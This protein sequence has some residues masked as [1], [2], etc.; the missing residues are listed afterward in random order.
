[1][2]RSILLEIYLNIF[3]RNIKL[4]LIKMDFIEFL[5]MNN[6]NLEIMKM[7]LNKELKVM[8]NGT[9]NLINLLFVSKDKKKLENF[10]NNINKNN[11]LSI[12]NL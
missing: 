5:I 8:V 6:M 9:K 3:L 10:Y 1:M 2:N 7:K 12:N 4:G 11:Y